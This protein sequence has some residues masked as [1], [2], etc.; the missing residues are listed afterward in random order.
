MKII[1]EKEEDLPENSQNGNYL[2]KK[3][4]EKKISKFFF[5]KKNAKIVPQNLEFQNSEAWKSVRFQKKKN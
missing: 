2:T 4:E 3:N 5:F 1:F